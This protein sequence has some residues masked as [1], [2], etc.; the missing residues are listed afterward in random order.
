MVC[1]ISPCRGCDRSGEGLENFHLVKHLARALVALA[2][3][4]AARLAKAGLD[5]G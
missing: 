5:L 4:S 1:R 2:A 3:T